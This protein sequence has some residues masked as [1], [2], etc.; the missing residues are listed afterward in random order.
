MHYIYLRDDDV[1]KYDNR[2]L[3]IFHL[4]KKYDIPLVLGVVPKRID[5]KLIHFLNKEKENTSYRFDIAQHGWSHKNYNK[6]MQNKYEFGPLRTYQQQKKD[7]IK[8]HDKMKECFGIN[9]TAA[10]I[11]PYH[12]YDSNTVKI[13][14]ELRI[15]IFS[16]EQKTK[17]KGKSFLDLPTQISLNDY[18]KNGVPIQNTAKT[19]IKR[20]SYLINNYEVCGM[21]FHHYVIKNEKQL[22]QFETFIKFLKKIEKEGIIKLT[23]F[24]R[25]LSFLAKRQKI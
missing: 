9:F 8:G 10:F 25:L 11:P 5:K 19:L 3:S 18:A 7:I 21:V 1:Y 23:S 17:L 16:A 6:D 4:A 22:K 14:N 20:F 2:F 15:P 13:I 24:S 12:G